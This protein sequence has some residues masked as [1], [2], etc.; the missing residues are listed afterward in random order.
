MK[1][2]CCSNIGTNLNLK[3]LGTKW[4]AL[5]KWDYPQHCILKP[6]TCKMICFVVFHFTKYK[7]GDIDYKSHDIHRKS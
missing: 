2:I 4:M 7:S 6:I 3:K 1:S 5:Q